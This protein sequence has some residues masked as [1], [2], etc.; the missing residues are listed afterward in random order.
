MNEGAKLCVE[1][2]YLYEKRTLFGW[3]YNID[4]CNRN[5]TE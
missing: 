3:Y 4:Q 1:Y 2:C 5:V